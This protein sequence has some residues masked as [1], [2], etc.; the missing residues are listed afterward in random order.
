M[1]WVLVSDEVLAV[2]A[3]IL[4]TL[5]VFATVLRFF[6]KSGMTPV[7]PDVSEAEV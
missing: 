7:M 3:F 1:S 5:P 4:G 2:L 6:A